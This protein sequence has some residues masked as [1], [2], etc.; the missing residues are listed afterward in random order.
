MVL[1]KSKPP[2]PN[3]I[4]FSFRR[5]GA[6]ERSPSSSEACRENRGAAQEDF[7]NLRYCSDKPIH[8]PGSHS[9]HDDPEFMEIPAWPLLQDIAQAGT[10]D[11][12]S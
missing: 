3:D 1:P 8:Q 12:Y 2:F 10:F 11:G 9:Q 4:S 7:E 5:R 6:Q